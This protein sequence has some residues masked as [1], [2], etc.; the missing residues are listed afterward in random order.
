MLAEWVESA[1]SMA[2]YLCGSRVRGDYRADSDVDVVLC[3]G[4]HPTSE[5]AQWWGKE[6]NENFASINARLPSRLEILEHDDPLRHEILASPAV[7]SDGRVVCVW[8]RP[9]PQW[10]N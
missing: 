8:T 10:A 2:I 5:D 3:F 7:H 4:N 1:P 9:K 6:N